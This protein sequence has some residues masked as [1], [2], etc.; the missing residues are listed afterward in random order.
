MMPGPGFSIVESV[1]HPTDFSEGSRI[2]FHHALKTAMLTR[3]TLT[4]L[5]VATD[6][7]ST[8]SNFPG[9]RETLE[10][11]GAL[12]K[13]SEKSAVGKL[14]IDAR[15]VVASEGE[16]VEM[17]VGYLA[18]HPADLIV[19]ATSQ[20]EGRVRWLGKSVAEPVVRKAGEMTL[21]IPGDTQGFVSADDG[22]V[23]L[24]KVLVPVALT[25]HPVTAVNVAARLV[26]RLNC[27][28]GTFTLMHVGNSNTMPALRLPEVPGWTWEKELRTGEVIKNIVEAAKDHEA[29]LI[30]MATDGRNGF[31]DGLRGSHSERVL[32]HV[33]TPLLTVPVGS[34]ASRFLT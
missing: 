9:V 12:P 7:N 34:R 2:A 30:V 22:S 32:R 27:P 33:T 6:D 21:L 1:L 13:G 19:L 25:P 5:H 17:V 11:W 15:K 8:W 31:L 14:G 16:P 23:N 10:R 29:D 26:E 3:S 4:L 20:R 18:K 28:Q 24:S